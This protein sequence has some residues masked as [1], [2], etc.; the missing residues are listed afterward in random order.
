VEPPRSRSVRA[1]ARPSIV[2]TADST[3]STVPTTVRLGCAPHAAESE[4]LCQLLVPF[5]GVHSK[6]ER[7]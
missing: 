4:S 2:P 5:K 7:S 1:I 6:T 3:A